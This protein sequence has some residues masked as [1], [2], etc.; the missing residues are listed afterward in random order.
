MEEDS[1]GDQRMQSFKFGEPTWAPAESHGGI[2]ADVVQEC[3]VVVV[4]LK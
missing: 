1:E 2:T 4:E 3:H